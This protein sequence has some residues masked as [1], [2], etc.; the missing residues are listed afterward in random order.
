MLKSLPSTYGL[1]PDGHVGP[2]NAPELVDEL[3]IELVEG[4]GEVVMLVLVLVLAV[5]VVLLVELVLVLLLVLVTEIVSILLE[6]LVLV[7]VCADE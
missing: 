3:D 2:G 1:L 4:L 6:K 7:E 5:V